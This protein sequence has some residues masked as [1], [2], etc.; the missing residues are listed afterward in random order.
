MKKTL[1]TV[2][3]AR[4]AFLLNELLRA[5]V[6]AEEVEREGRCLRFRVRHEDADLVERILRERGVTFQTAGYRGIKSIVKRIFRRPFLIASIVVTIVGI[7]FFESFVYDYT[8]EGNHYVNTE[9]VAAVLRAHEVDGFTYKKSI[10]LKEI[11]RE[12]SAIDGVSFASVK[13]VG[14]RLRVEIAEELPHESPDLPSY[15][16]ICSSYHAVVTKVVAESGTARVAPGD[17]VEEGNLLIEPLYAFTEGGVEAP[18]RGEVW[19]R[20]TYRKE[21]LLPSFTAESVL[22]GETVRFRALYLFGREVTKPHL[23]PFD[24]YDYE[25]RTIYRGIGV[26]VVERIYCRRE[27]KTIYHDFDREAPALIEKARRELMIGVPFYAQERGVSRVTQKKLDN[28]L[29]IVIY[30]IVEQRI[31]PLP[32]AR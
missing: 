27:I 5:K 23:P 28:V 8:V 10:D 15:E 4:T 1:F 7:L 31:D 32:I 22:T 9:T 30:Y 21:V 20:V 26:S 18:A 17:V 25:E 13:I 6:A 16:P 11:K 19:G 12:I 3:S 24:A 14:N 29:H 2:Q